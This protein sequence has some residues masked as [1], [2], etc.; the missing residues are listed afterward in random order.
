[1]ALAFCKNELE[2]KRTGQRATVPDNDI[3]KLMYYLKCVC[4][5]IDCN[6]DPEIQRFT[7]YSNWHRLSVDEQRQLLVLCY[8]FSPD[9]FDGKVSFRVTLSVA[10][11]AMN[12][13][14]LIR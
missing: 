8:T 4:T 2:I 1:M 6:N 9:V 7:N 13:T 12:S 14:K 10:T 5:T 3:A 11:A